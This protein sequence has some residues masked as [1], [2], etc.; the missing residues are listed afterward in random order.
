MAKTRGDAGT[1]WG[2]ADRTLKERLEQHFADREDLDRRVKKERAALDAQCFRLLQEL[3]AKYRNLN[4]AA[5]ASLAARKEQ[6]TTDA[7]QREAARLR[8]LLSRMTAG[9]RVTAGHTRVCARGG[10]S[11]FRAASMKSD[12]ALTGDSGMGPNTSNQH[13][14]YRRTEHTVTIEHFDDDELHEDFR[15]LYEG[16]EDEVLGPE[17]ESDE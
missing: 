12:H 6:P 1:I 17:E 14:T 5:R 4:V 13:P 11:R 3:R 10:H 9:K 15:D 7:I 2:M 16:E 8:K